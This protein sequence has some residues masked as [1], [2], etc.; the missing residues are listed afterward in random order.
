[1]GVLGHGVTDPDV[2]VIGGGFAGLVAARDLREA[3]RSVVL[4]EARDRLG[5][6]TWFREL[7][8]TGVKVEYGGAWFW[9]DAHPGLAAEIARY[10]IATRPSRQVDSMAWLTAGELRSGPG[11]LQDVRDALVPFE[12]M[13]EAAASRIRAARESGRA[14]L[15]DL[16]VPMASWIAGA[17]LPIETTD[18]L[19]AYTAAMGGGDPARIS[20]L[21]VI[22]DAAILEYR[23]DDVFAGVGESF[24]E[25]TASLVEALA[26]DVG[27]EFR[28]EAVVT[29][30]E[31]DDQGVTVELKHGGRISARAGALTLPVNVWSDIAF[32]PPLSPEKRR[33]AALGHPGAS[34]KVLAVARGV[35]AGFV[36]AG[37]P[38]ALQAVVGESE[39][40]GGRLVVGFSGVGGIDP[41]DPAAVG[42]ALRAYLPDSEVLTSD[43]HD[44][45]ADPYS[46]GTWFAAPPGWEIGDA[47]G[48][49]APEGR[50]AF[51]GGDIAPV[52]AGWIEG[53]IV[54]GGDAAR[55]LLSLDS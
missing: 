4:L 11:V 19:R 48:Q 1:M 54:S 16:D 23:F 36:S 9:S 33:I 40:A 45:V 37:W 21:G 29:R 44:W 49:S 34:T 22:A 38:A 5:G 3:G 10:G 41:S 35:P 28:L 8:G 31:R 52:G 30:I 26:K 12:P 46:K 53:A 39:V 20:A 47:E 6:R 25:G 13:F 50:L 17:G 2:V 7:P 14:D 43:G 51:A 42:V 32:E 27:G 18:F 15:A 24:V 55:R